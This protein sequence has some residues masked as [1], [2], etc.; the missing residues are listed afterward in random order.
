MECLLIKD[1]LLRSYLCENIS[2]GRMFVKRK[3]PFR[4]KILDISPRIEAVTWY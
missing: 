4:N 1:G 2:Y 3:L